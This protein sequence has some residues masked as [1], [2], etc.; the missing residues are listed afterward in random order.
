[1]E[2]TNSANVQG[3]DT[4][5]TKQ[6]LQTVVTRREAVD[7]FITKPASAGTVGSPARHHVTIV[8][9]AERSS[10]QIVKCLPHQS[11]TYCFPAE[12]QHDRKKVQ[13]KRDEAL[14]KLKKKCLRAFYEENPYLRAPLTPKKA[15][16]SSSLNK[17]NIQKDMLS[18]KK[19]VVLDKAGS[20]TDE[21]SRETDLKD[22]KLTRQAPS[23]AGLE[24]W[25]QRCL[26]GNLPSLAEAADLLFG[27]VL[28]PEKKGATDAGRNKKRAL[29][30]DN[31][32]QECKTAASGTGRSLEKCELSWCNDRGPDGGLV[33]NS[34][35]DGVRPLARTVSGGMLK[36]PPLANSASSAAATEDVWV[37]CDKCAKWRRLPADTNPNDLPNRWYCRMNTDPN[38]A[39]CSV[40]EETYAEK[41]ELPDPLDQVKR[42]RVGL[43]VMRQKC[44]DRFEQKIKMARPADIETKASSG[45]NQKFNWIRC[46]NPGCTRW[47]VLS[48]IVPPNPSALLN[49]LVHTDMEWFC[50]MNSWD[51]S[52]A[53]CAAPEDVGFDHNIQN[54]VAETLEF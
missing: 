16:M 48:N 30:S 47:R 53:S 27:P 5:N 6:E 36:E 38:R 35:E 19:L 7:V 49:P 39:D 41:V 25:R 17:S 15:S 18:P 37:C 32:S 8:P 34:S 46:C 22:S 4:S 31:A 40:P 26:Q 14:A 23:A 45:R 42:Q 2:S 10:V 50:W 21:A 33:G 51:N 43:W 28:K 44:R 52:L 11:L 9:P 1:M 13:E 3:R 24:I 29:K 54:F 12:C 20:K